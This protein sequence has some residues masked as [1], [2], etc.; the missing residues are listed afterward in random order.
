VRPTNGWQEHRIP[1]FDDWNYNYSRDDGAGIDD[2]PPVTPCFD[3]A[4]AMQTAAPPADQHK[5]KKVKYSR[6]TTQQYKENIFSSTFPLVLLRLPAL[7]SVKRLVHLYLSECRSVSHKNLVQRGPLKQP[8]C[9]SVRHIWCCHG[10]T[11]SADAREGGERGKLQPRTPPF[12]A[13][14]KML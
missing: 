10:R 11:L 12:E 1:A 4:S 8:L 2:W 9:T 7:L 6:S 14:K 13:T 3:F 5:S